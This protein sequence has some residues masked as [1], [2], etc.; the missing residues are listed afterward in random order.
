MRDRFR[1]EAW[2]LCWGGN[3]RHVV[4][5][6][7]ARIAIRRLFPSYEP[8]IKMTCASSRCKPTVLFII[9]GLSKR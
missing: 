6:A 7:A 4:G 9:L 8:N 3:G 2:T 1:L 5:L